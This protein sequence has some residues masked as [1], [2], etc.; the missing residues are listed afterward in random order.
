MAD[1]DFMTVLTLAAFAALMW[2]I[3]ML[4]LFLTDKEVKCKLKNFLKKIFKLF[5]KEKKDG[6]QKKTRI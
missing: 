4:I 5:K 6:S 1:F 3:G 2:M